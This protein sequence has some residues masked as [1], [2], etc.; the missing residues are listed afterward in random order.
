MIGKR[1]RELRRGAKLTQKELSDH[2]GVSASAVGMYE[3]DRRT[4]DIETIAVICGM[5]NIT[6]DYLLFGK[7]AVPNDVAAEQFLDGIK[8]QIERHKGLL[9]ERLPGG[10][11][12][13]FSDTEMDKLS[14]AICIGITMALGINT[15][16]DD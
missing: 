2:L 3:Q 9:Y 5:F 13:Y 12:R 4:P 7:G 10:R 8:Q 1:I 11:Q 15:R 6:A 16:K 14:D